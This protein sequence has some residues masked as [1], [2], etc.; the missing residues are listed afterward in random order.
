MNK[1]PENR[2]D[3][4]ELLANIKQEEEK[5][6]QGKLKIFFGMCAG[7][8]KT[9]AML[10]AG[11]LEKAKGTDIVIG[12]V[13]T[14]GRKDTI[15]QIANLEQI[16]RKTY[17]YK[18]TSVEEMDL[19]A[20]IARKPQL[21]LVDELAHTNAPGSRHAKRYQDVLE[22]LDN[23]I[24]VYTTVNV[25]HL[26]SRADTVA[27]ITGTIVRETLP[28]DF[29]ERAD[30]IEL[31]DL[32]PSELLQRLSDGK[33]YTPERSQEAIQNFFRK[34]NITALREMSLRIA[35]ESVDKQLRDYMHLKRIHGP[36]KS[37]VHL[38]V[39]ISPSPN[40][41]RLLRYAKTL[42]D[43]MG[44]T[45]LAVY[46]ETDLQL[47]TEQN[48]Q[49]AK[50]INLAKQLGAELVT[51]SGT[52]LVETLVN[53]AMKE[54]ITHIIVGKRNTGGV[55]SKFYSN[56]FISKL[57]K[58]C[59]DID[60]Y[61]LGFEHKQEKS[62]FKPPTF[63]SFSWGQY[64]TAFL[65]VIFSAVG[66]FMLTPQLGYQIVSYVLLFEVSIMAIFMEMGPVLLASTLAALSWNY[67]FIPPRFTFHID[68][69][70]DVLMFAIFFIVA[71][72]N[73]VFT[74]R[75]KK[76]ER[77]TRLRE[78]RTSALFKLTKELNQVVG[79]KDVEKISKNNIKRYFDFEAEFILQNG[80]D[81]LI[82]PS[83]QT[84]H[85]S[86][87]GNEFSVA[88]WTYKHKQKAGKYTDTLPSSAYTFYPLMGNS[89]N[90]GVLMISSKKK[91]SGDLEIFWDTFLSQI[92]NKL[93]R[94]FLKDMAKKAQILDESDRLYKTLFNSISHELR[95]PVATIMG[96]SDTL[97]TQNYPEEI[98]RD[99][100]TEVNVASE[101]LNR[102]I[103]NL[104]NMSR[105]ETGRITAKVDWCDV[106]DLANKV[107]NSLKKELKPYGVPVVIDDDMPLVQLD[108]GLMEQVI[109]NLMVNATQH[110][111]EGTNIRLKMF[112]D[113]GFLTIQVMDRG[114]GFPPEEIGF[115]FNKF[116]RCQGAKAGGTGLGLSIVKG[117]VEAHNGTVIAENRAHGGACFTIKIPTK[118]SEINSDDRLI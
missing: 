88:S 10:Q 52:D 115:V 37:G 85:L 97:L 93:E 78:E 90:P 59:G 1:S 38:M 56:R 6:K 29:F 69:L 65:L 102:L 18:S 107:V 58:F 46:V 87:S 74:V 63:V 20:I 11:Q 4:D 105:L 76:Q 28:D 21:V 14:H 54:N 100:L 60:L 62:S 7:V 9:Y 101:R 42:A 48:E 36:W 45:V 13:E 19:D 40:S 95:I 73:A 106:H 34:G 71:M 64:I 83:R 22:I 39:A 81:E 118:I 92:A 5:E 30:E 77:L 117:F 2:P 33:V 57:M 86:V 70:Q 12:L 51:T 27:Q 79:F 110:A 114:T 25:Q 84:H 99:L 82:K 16:P 17:N 116:Y 26:E 53:V 61:I 112:Y 15:E 98:R 91:L 108:F 24:D 67:L 49:L 43:S 8:G 3:P 113:T 72:V 68:Q 32:T 80:I 103:E 66:L 75:V 41:T 96:A 94:E 50:N 47:S 104:L 44:A 35:A 89:I 31:I 109:Y 55:I 23:G 111:P